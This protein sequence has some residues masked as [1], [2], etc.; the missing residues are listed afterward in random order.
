MLDERITSLRIYRDD[1]SRN[2]E[3][4]VAVLNNERCFV[5]TIPTVNIPTWN[6][7]TLRIE[8]PIVCPEPDLLTNQA[9]HAASLALEGWIYLMDA[10][11]IVT[12]HHEAALFAGQEP[13]PYPIP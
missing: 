4:F 6:N 1:N 9:T 5:V 10:G 13:G 7:A 2:D 12:I 11:D 3:E 8:R